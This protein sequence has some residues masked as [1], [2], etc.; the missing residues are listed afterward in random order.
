MTVQ[1][2][3]AMLVLAVVLAVTVAPA[4]HADHGPPLSGSPELDRIVAV[5]LAAAESTFG[6]KPC[7]HVAWSDTV[8]DLRYPGQP[9][10]A[11]QGGCRIWLVRGAFGTADPAPAVWCQV[12]VHEYGHNVEAGDAHH[13]I[14]P[15]V[16]LDPWQPALIP[17]CADAGPAPVAV[18]PPA[19]RGCAAT[20]RL[21]IRRLRAWL[22]R[23]DRHCERLEV[24]LKRGRVSVRRVNRCW[25]RGDDVDDRLFALEARSG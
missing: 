20:C 2:G 14:G 17:A 8:P 4:G 11:E 5:G 7:V 25:D 16:M 12:V 24:A 10:A 21:R 9:A 19:R 13:T 15:P 1:R 18:E 22:R 3:L 6:A 23:L